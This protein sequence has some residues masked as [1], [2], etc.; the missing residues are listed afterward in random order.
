MSFAFFGVMVVPTL[1]Q[2][3]SVPQHSRALAPNMPQVHETIPERVR[4][5]DTTSSLDRRGRPST[6]A[7]KGF[8]KQ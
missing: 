5:P 2:V 6:A 1:A 7:R 4:D 8:M 3:P